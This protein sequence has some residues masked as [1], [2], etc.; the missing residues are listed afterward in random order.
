MR[1]K[2]VVV[3]IISALVLWGIVVYVDF[4]RVMNENELPLFTYSK[5]VLMNDGG[6]GTYQ[7][8]FYKVEIVGYNRVT[9]E[10][11]FISFYFFNRLFREKSKF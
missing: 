1:I 3:T 6:S 8:V 9:R 11:D 10:S 5:K 4:N 7:G 2:R